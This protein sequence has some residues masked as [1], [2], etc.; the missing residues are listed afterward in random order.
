VIMT[1]TRSTRAFELAKLGRDVLDVGNRWESIEAV[2]HPR[3]RRADPRAMRKRST[4]RLADDMTTMLCVLRDVL[5]PS[6][7]RDDDALRSASL[8]YGE[9]D[10]CH[11]HDA[12]RS[13]RRAHATRQPSRQPSG[14]CRARCR[15]GCAVG[16]IVPVITHAYCHGR[17][18]PLQQHRRQRGPLCSGWQLLPHTA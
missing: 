3:A 18:R 6:R 1:R 5:L 13:V 9:P 7:R 12:V 4:Y 10:R 16:V 2:R 15:C 17:G 8:K 14:A 11:V